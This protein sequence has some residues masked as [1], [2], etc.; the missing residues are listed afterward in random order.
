MCSKF[1]SNSINLTLFS[2][3][4]QLISGVVY[5]IVMIVPSSSSLLVLHCLHCHHLQTFFYDYLWKIIVDIL[6]DSERGMLRD[7]YFSPYIIPV[8]EHIPWIYK[9]IPI[10]PGLRD[11]VMQILR[12]RMK[13]GVY[14][15]S[16]ASYRSL[17]FC[18]T[19]KEVGKVRLVHNLQP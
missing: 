3:F 4:Y 12:D 7:D 18:V 6:Q 11:Q 16:Q 19:K 15:P 10:P 2:A 17:W 9:N 5:E 13:A 1:Q 8:V 14:E